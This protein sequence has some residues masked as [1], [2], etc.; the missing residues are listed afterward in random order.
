MA[1]AT[2][3]VLV[4]ETRVAGAVAPLVTA[5]VVLLM[6]AI[7]GSIVTLRASRETER[8]IAVQQAT[9]HDVS[10]QTNGLGGK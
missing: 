6:V 10:A 4:R 9:G 1:A 2:D 8:S 5:F 7:I 3:E